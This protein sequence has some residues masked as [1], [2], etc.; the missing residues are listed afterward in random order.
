MKGKQGHKETPRTLQAPNLQHEA[1]GV[2]PECPTDRWG[3]TK[4]EKNPSTTPTLP[5][6]LTAAAHRAALE[7]GDKRCAFLFMSTFHS[8][9][10]TPILS[11]SFYINISNGIIFKGPWDTMLLPECTP[12]CEATRSSAFQ[13]MASGSPSE[14]RKANKPAESSRSPQHG[15]N[16]A[17]G[18]R[19]RPLCD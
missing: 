8:E 4:P 15:D 1:P 17:D 3:P 10:N 9:H 14:Q 2:Y 18:P 16:P 7:M 12:A 6:A 11:P 19:V 5:G 13:E